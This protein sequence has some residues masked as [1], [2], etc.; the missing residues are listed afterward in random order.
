MGAGELVV[1]VPVVGVPG[2]ELVAGVDVDVVV[3]DSGP[4]RKVGSGLAEPG[5][6]GAMAA[7]AL[8]ATEPR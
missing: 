8:S 1:G 6:A 2:V 7:S 5:V 4:K 3:A